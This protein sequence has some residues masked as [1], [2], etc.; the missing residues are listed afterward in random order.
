MREHAFEGVI[1]NLER[2]YRETDSIVVREELAKYVNTRACPECAGTRLRL[3]H[4]HVTRLETGPGWHAYLEALARHVADPAA[5]R[6]RE[7]WFRRF[8]ELEPSYTERFAALTP[9]AP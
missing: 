5:E 3:R 2:R 8:T 7:A 1:P 4:E 9:R 6:D